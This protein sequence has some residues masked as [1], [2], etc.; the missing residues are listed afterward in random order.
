MS[1]IRFALSLV[2]VAASLALLAGMAGLLG[3]LLRQVLRLVI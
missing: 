2:A 1:Q 3:L